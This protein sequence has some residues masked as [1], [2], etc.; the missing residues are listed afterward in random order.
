[1]GCCWFLGSLGWILLGTDKNDGSE[2][3]I[4][5]GQVDLVFV[6]QVHQKQFLVHLMNLVGVIGPF[7]F[8]KVINVILI[9]KDSLDALKELHC[10]TYGFPVSGINP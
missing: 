8:S 9:Q 7:V 1:M 3:L 5:R 4:Q 2:A 6:L 10:R